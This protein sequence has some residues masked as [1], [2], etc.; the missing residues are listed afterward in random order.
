MDVKTCDLV[1]ERMEM[2]V[3]AREGAARA[4]AG[5]SLMGT[6]AWCREVVAQKP[7]GQ[8]VA[9]PQRSGS[10]AIGAT[11]GNLGGRAGGRCHWLTPFN[12]MIQATW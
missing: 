7:G 6:G 4:K 8:E 10:G 11:R 3:V 1:P 5:Y 12:G 2:R 9:G